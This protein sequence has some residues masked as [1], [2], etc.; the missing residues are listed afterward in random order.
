MTTSPTIR[1]QTSLA[2]V[3]VRDAQ[4]QPM[5]SAAADVFVH[6]GARKEDISIID[7][8]SLFHIPLVVKSLAES[9]DFDGVVI[10][11]HALRSDRDRYEMEVPEVY[12]AVMDIMTSTGMPLAVGIA[13]CKSAR[14]CA[15]VHRTVA[16]RA[17]KELTILV[18]R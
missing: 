13:L 2:V 8:P 1:A 18:S 15:S 11:A 3:V 4:T 16:Q 12:R 9:R 10:L 7:A 5:V 6:A 17:A 14:A